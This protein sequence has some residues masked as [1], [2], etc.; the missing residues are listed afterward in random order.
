MR[1]GNKQGLYS[2]DD[3]VVSGSVDF[4]SM[5]PMSKTELWHMRLGHVS[6]KGLVE[7]GKQNLLG[8]DKVEKLK[9]YETYV[10]GKSYSD[11]L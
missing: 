6:E 5:K 4:A 1:G 11:V 9:F 10:F 7:L 8:G 3:A 2:L